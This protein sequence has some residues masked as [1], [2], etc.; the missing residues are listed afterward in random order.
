[1]KS[2]LDCHGLVCVA[3]A[4]T[5]LGSVALRCLCSGNGKPTE[6]HVLKVDSTFVLKVW[7][8]SCYVDQCLTKKKK[9]AL[10]DTPHSKAGSDPD[11]KLSA[12]N[13]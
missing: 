7:L 9:N 10:V 2:L 11:S 1:M 12:T 4:G 3:V 5:H 6:M 13:V 8:L